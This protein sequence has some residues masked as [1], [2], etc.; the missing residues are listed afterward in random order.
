M[1]TARSLPHGCYLADREKK[2][3]YEVRD[4]SSEGEVLLAN[5]GD[6]FGQERLE[7]WNVRKVLSDL[8]LIRP[9]S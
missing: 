8:E 1:A 2:Q 7:W 4:G 9:R 5:V 3:L 6:P